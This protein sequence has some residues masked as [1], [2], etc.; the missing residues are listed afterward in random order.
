MLTNI[1][2]QKQR[3]R[4]LEILKKSLL[5]LRFYIGTELYK[6]RYRNFR[7]R[8]TKEAAVLGIAE[9]VAYVATLLD[10]GNIEV[11]LKRLNE[12]T[13][14]LLCEPLW[15]RAL[16]IP[17]LDELARKA[18]LMIA[19]P[20]CEATDPK[21][22]VH[23]ASVVHPTGGHTRVIE[24][25]AAALPEYRHVLVITD[26]GNLAPND[27]APLRSRFEA[28]RLHVR[29]LTAPGW[30]GKTRELSSTI[31]RLSPQAIM[32]FAHYGDSIAFVGVPSRTVRRV[33][34]FHQCDHFPALG[35][36]RTD[37]THVDLTPGCHR[38]C[39]SRRGLGASL[40]NLTVRDIGT[41]HVRERR[42]I[43]GVTCGSPHKYAGRGE[44]SYAELL[45]ALFSSGV[46]R[47]L[48][49]GEM[50]ESQKDRICA[51]I[52]AN[53]Q[54]ATR[55]VFLPNTPSLAK[56]LVELG[57]DFYL[58]SYPMGGGKAAVEA[59]CVGLPI[60]AP[61]TAGAS[62]L[63]NVDMTFGTSVVVSEL[64]QVPA[65]VRRLESE[66][67]A[68]SQGSRAVYEEHYS[69]SAFRQGLL[70]AIAGEDPRDQIS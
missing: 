34:F 56:K 6:R 20:H 33:V 39:E 19:P 70:W 25:I 21:L 44:F 41:V 49:I 65:A 60:L 10:R 24:D 50:S 5:R 2:T 52:R 36:T 32:L 46:A 8:G 31:A 55:A 54:D 68:L 42:P 9:N 12:L 66:K 63:L 27:L 15:G 28:L 57:P 61:H 22:L 29:L 23:V 35:A 40:L 13:R 37:Y 4:P 43:F 18:S 62:P 3:D 11:F 38:F 17:E 48:H 69:W 51:D 45:A 67:E 30:L 64:A 7:P 58:E 1:P 16:F 26:M 14:Q 59:M 47:M 53:G